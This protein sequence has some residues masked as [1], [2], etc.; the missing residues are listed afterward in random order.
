MLQANL[1]TYGAVLFDVERQA[2]GAFIAK[3]GSG[4]ASI[5]GEKAFRISGI[6]DL[7]LEVVWLTNLEQDIHWQ[8]SL[9]NIPQ[10]KESRYL[11]VEMNQMMRE[12]GVS[13]KTVG[14]A[15]SVEA[16]GELFG[17]I[18][19]IAKQQYPKIDYGRSSLIGELTQAMG[20]HDEVYEDALFDEAFACSFQDRV[21]CYKPDE[22]K[23]ARW[24]TLRA[25]RV[26]HAQRLVGE[27]F[28]I[29]RG[30]WRFI[31]ERDMPEKEKRMDW[32]EESFAGMPY[33]VKIKKMNFFKPA[34]GDLFN[35]L[36][37]I[38]MGEAILPG[39]QR[40]QREWMPMPE[41]LYV[42]R[43]AEVEFDS[44][45]VG[46]S[47]DLPETPMLPPLAHMMHHSYAWG[48]LAEN[49]WMTMASRSINPHAKS[50]TMVSPRATW[51]RAIDRFYS[52]NAAVQMSLPG[53]TKILHY[54]HGSVT[55]ACQEPDM[56]QIIEHAVKAGLQA[57][58]SSYMHWQKWKEKELRA[59]MERKTF[60]PAA[61]ASQIKPEQK[62]TAVEGERNE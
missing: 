62:P 57:P 44:V 36:E 13:P 41:L 49:I 34:E 4:W 61:W 35:A 2:N 21:E 27:D 37:L 10:I 31:G 47:Y 17:R 19:R 58:A 1:S 12:L 16:I 24:L 51:L 38:K 23:Q 29:P 14:P 26:L 7:S 8:A 18:M 55:I 43:F 56:G 28:M 5:E 48:V 33:M 39:R 15:H 42:R 22:I 20:L 32:L 45:C 6:H 46:A 25:P 30:P 52:F 11:R 54:G 60:T 53:L 50:K 40:R 9:F 59:H 3:P